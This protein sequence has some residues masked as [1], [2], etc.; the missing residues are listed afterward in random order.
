MENMPWNGCA[1]GK[2][3]VASGPMGWFWGGEDIPAHKPFLDWSLSE[4]TEM[5]LDFY[6]RKNWSPETYRGTAWRSPGKPS[7]RDFHG[8]F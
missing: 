5:G 6:W 8:N 3:T 1:V 7:L 4:E 2:K